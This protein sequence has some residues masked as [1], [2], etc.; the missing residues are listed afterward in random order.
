MGRERKAWEKR[1]GYVVR[2]VR[3]CL[4][5]LKCEHRS[6]WPPWR[7]VRDTGDVQPVAPGSVCKHWRQRAAK[8]VDAP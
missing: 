2:K 1:V 7:C 8:A 5:C 3:C 6:V 4:S